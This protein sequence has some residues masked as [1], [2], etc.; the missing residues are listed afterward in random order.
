MFS[1]ATLRPMLASLPATDPPLT[2]P[3]LVYEP[4]YDGIRAIALVEPAATRARVR[5]WSRLGNEK[6]T[7]FPELAEAL[8]LWGRRLRGPV[9]LDGEIVALDA[10]GRPA[11][12]QRLQH[13]IH[14][15]VPGYR[16]S[17]PILSADQQ[18]TAF[19]AFD[20][21]RDDDLDLRPLPLS[22]RRAQLERLFTKYK[23]PA[24][25]IRLSE[26]VAG[27]GRALLERA[28]DEGW[29]G[30]LVKHAR[31][32]YRDGRRSPE[33][34]KLKI[35]HQD[36][37]IVGGWTEP[38]GA[39]SRF[40]SLILGRYDDA[41]RLVHAGDVGTGFTATELERLWKMLKS[42]E[43]DACPFHVK[44]KT[45]GRPHWVKPQ[46]IVQVRYT[47]W[48]DDGRLRHPAYLGLRDDKMPEEVIGSSASAAKGRSG[49][50]LPR[51]TMNMSEGG[52]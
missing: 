47:E 42:L 3:L 38:K 2:D 36:E 6:T 41:R 27:D 46:L 44:P 26:Q 10:K 8:G 9:V 11:G 13:R 48:T 21:L 7:Q 12:F 4:K 37:F 35:Q 45:L 5:F 31:S 23:P 29:E 40:G 30:L 43:I 32:V 18:P 20:L 52:K 24:P 19:I 25:A 28:H 39:R 15:T 51:L 22:E 50:T 1:A 14:V 17:K 33:W 34:R 16:S 49:E